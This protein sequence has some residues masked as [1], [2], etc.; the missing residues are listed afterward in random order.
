MQSP[1]GNVV[2]ASLCTGCVSQV[3][4]CPAL[5]CCATYNCQR[6]TFG[7]CSSTCGNGVQVQPAT[8]FRN[9]D[10]QQSQ[11]ASSFCD[12]GCDSATMPCSQ[13]P[14]PATPAPVQPAPAP[15]V[16]VPVFVPPTTF[17]PVQPVVYYTPPVQPVVYYAPPATFAP[18]QPVFY[19][20]PAEPAVYYAPPAQPVVYY[21]PPTTFAPVQPVVYYNPPPSFVQTPVFVQ[22]PVQ[23]FVQTP[24]FVQPPVQQQVVYGTLYNGGMGNCRQTST[25]QQIVSDSFCACLSVGQSG[26]CSNP[27]GRRRLLSSATQKVRV[28]SRRA[29]RKPQPAHPKRP[30]AR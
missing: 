14:V 13:C 19:A 8:C 15:T 24:V 7:A 25:N 30:S 26:D 27:F 20:P 23:Q 11:V 18:V 29:A 12:R 17:A 22:P 9:C 3:I 28:A 5:T 1:G 6:G 21:A 2:S 16:Y 4:P 10:G